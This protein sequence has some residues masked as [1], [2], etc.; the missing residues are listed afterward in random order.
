MSHRTIQLS[1]FII[2]GLILVGLIFFIFKPF[3]A[4]IFLSAVLAITFHPLYLYF[5]GRFVGRKNLSAMLTVL[6]IVLFIVIP[7]TFL[8]A[9]ILREAVDLYNK[10]AFE[11]GSAGIASFFQTILLKIESVLP[12]ENVGTTVD[13][14]QYSRSLLSWIIGQTDNVLAVIFG[15][16]F[17]F[18]L[19][20]LTIYYMLIQGEKIKRIILRWSPLPD[21]YDQ[22]FIST[23]RRSVD[24][25]IRG[26]IL[27]SIGQGVMVGLGFAIF[28]V[29]SPVLWG[30]VGAI[31][32]LVP[33]V[34]T[35]IVSV[36]AIAYLFFVGDIGSGIGL[37][38]WSALCVGFI[39]NILSFI[40]FKD[41][42]RVH[43]LLVLF[44]ILGGVE[45][46][47]VIGFLV[48]PVVVSALVALAKIYPFVVPFQNS[49]KS[50]AE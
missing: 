46:F 26:R 37:L 44:S 45:L 30:F 48:G 31:L 7:V 17:K 14:D 15:G 19:M 3:L 33:I 40:F 43:P 38:L 23:L 21:D 1:F 24:A 13:V 9:G 29:G 4:V 28:G 10:L 12:Q 32:S 50:E 8:S 11:G 5:L 20:L 6:A 34:G 2:A 16:L 25:V 18:I 49:L 41:R 39:D 35:A 36:P 27:V 42:I 47:G 22:E